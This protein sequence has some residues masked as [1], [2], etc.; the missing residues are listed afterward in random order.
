MAPFSLK[1]YG[2]RVTPRPD[3][4]TSFLPYWWA[5]ERCACASEFDVSSACRSF[6]G[7][8]RCKLPFLG[9]DTW[10]AITSQTSST[11]HRQSTL[12]NGR[13]SHKLHCA[14]N[15]CRRHRPDSWRLTGCLGAPP[16]VLCRVPR[17]G[18]SVSAATHRFTLAGAVRNKYYGTT[19]LLLGLTITGSGGFT[20]MYTHY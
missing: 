19:V 2:V 11:P 20:K 12:R 14:S 1:Y 6:M 5:A 7:T 4:Y 16:A 10:L 18:A 13:R 8:C 9:L 17:V 3:C 15:Y